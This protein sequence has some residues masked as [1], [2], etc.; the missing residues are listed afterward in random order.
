MIMRGRWQWFGLPGHFIGGNKCR[1]HLCTRVGKYLVSTVGDY[2]DSNGERQE[3]GLGRFFETMVFR[4]GKACI[5][6]SCNCLMPTLKDPGREL[7]FQGYK[8]AGEAQLGH[9]LTCIRWSG[10]GQ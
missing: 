10:K 9:M 4:C 2:Y 7:D 8:T 3:I 6:P 5:E 1:F